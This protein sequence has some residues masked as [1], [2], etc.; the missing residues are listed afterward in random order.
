VENAAERIR[1]RRHS[2]HLC[3]ISVTLS[4]IYILFG[5]L[6]RWRRRSEAVA[7]PLNMSAWLG[8]PE[9]QL[10]EQNLAKLPFQ[11][12]QLAQAD[13][14]CSLATMLSKSVQGTE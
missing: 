7:Y 6:F 3:H 14:L 11:M 12:F 4:I 10:L 9:R 5:I 2:P 1:A 13:L 8:S